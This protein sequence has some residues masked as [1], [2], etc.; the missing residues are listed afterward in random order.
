MRREERVSG[1]PSRVVLTRELSVQV[2]P[3]GVVLLPSALSALDRYAERSPRS[4]DALL[5]LPAGTCTPCAVR[6]PVAEFDQR[7][8]SRAPVRSRPRRRQG[9]AVRREDTYEVDGVVKIKDEHAFGKFPTWAA[10][11]SASDC[12]RGGEK[13]CGARA[14]TTKVALTMLPPTSTS[15]SFGPS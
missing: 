12:R 13:W 11:D 9:R 14:F 15:P 5:P 10:L 7:V 8:P 4:P 1:C 6:A 2:P 3:P